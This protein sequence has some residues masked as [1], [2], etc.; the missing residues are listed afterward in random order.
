MAM[1]RSSASAPI[2]PAL[3]PGSGDYLELSNHRAGRARSRGPPF[4]LERPQ[5]LD[6]RQSQL[7]QLGLTGIDI[8]L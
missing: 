2:R 1:A 4:H 5:C 7:I 6:E 8:L 3:T